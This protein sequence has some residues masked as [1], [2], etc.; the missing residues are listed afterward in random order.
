MNVPWTKVYMDETEVSAVSELIR[1][2]WVSMGS[3][4]RELEETLAR[5]VGVK[6]AVALNSGTAALDTS[7]KVLG[8]GPGDEVIVPAFTYIAT[9]N[10]VLL[11]HA[12]PVFA[13][14]SPETLN[15][16]IASP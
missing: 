2:S 9:A 8:I 3:Q 11:Q 14:I 15:S 13:E 16:A 1:S 7:L 6:H 4:V 12:I 10:A 5:Y